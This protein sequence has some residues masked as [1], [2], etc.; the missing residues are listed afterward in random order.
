LVA[1]FASERPPKL[2]TTSLRVDAPAVEGYKEV[3]DASAPDEYDA[4][5]SYKR[6]LGEED[7]CVLGDVNDSGVYAAAES[8]APDGYPVIPSG[9]VDGDVYCSGR[10][11]AGGYEFALMVGKEFEGTIGGTGDIKFSNGS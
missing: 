5:E 9:Y 2:S 7:G 10:Y 1:G 11:P 3:P 4:D 8:Y 6:P